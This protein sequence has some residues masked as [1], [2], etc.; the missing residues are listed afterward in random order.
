M[1]AI[2]SGSGLGLF[3]SSVSSL[4]QSGV[5]GDPRAGRG[6]DQVY[7]NSATGNLIVQ[8]QDEILRS[9][10]LDLSL[11]RTYNSLG[12]MTDSD[13]GDNWRLG[14]D[15][16]VYGLSGTL[17]QA[18]SSVIKVFGDGTEVTYTYD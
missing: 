13:N 8:G 15:R 4:G 10:G 17:N 1:V 12:L 5:A 7:V 6:G 16:K 14:V 11:V 3:R 18:N 9:L 2:V